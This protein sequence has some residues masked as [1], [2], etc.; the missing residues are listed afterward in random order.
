MQPSRNTFTRIY[1]NWKTPIPPRGNRRVIPF[2]EWHYQFCLSVSNFFRCF[3]DALRDPSKWRI[4]NLTRLCRGIHT[5][6]NIVV[7]YQIQMICHG[8]KDRRRSKPG[9]NLH[10]CRSRFY[11][12]FSIPLHPWHR[13]LLLVRTVYILSQ[14]EWFVF[15][16]F[17]TFHLIFL[18]FINNLN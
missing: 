3:S 17:N 1:K 9:S 10:V 6:R 18:I 2:K 13:L 14:K 15:F 12:I 11:F 4:G 7:L 5:G 16:N 8:G